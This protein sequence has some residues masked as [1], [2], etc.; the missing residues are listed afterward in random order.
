VN[1]FE[2]V[3]QK[4]RDLITK[5]ALVLVDGMLRFD[6]FSDS[7]R[8]SAKRLT[9]LD[10]VRE[11]QARRLVLKWPQNGDAKALQGR[12]YEILTA[13]RP[14]PCPILIEYTLQR[15]QSPW[16]GAFTLGNDWTV[17][18]TRELLEQLETL[19]GRGGVQVLYGAP[20]P[21]AASMSGS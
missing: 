14:G 16:T 10:K 21:I 12:L 4:Y 6:E 2:D 9:E 7:W 11:Q 19:V 8:L 15:A 17:R 20:P 5:D 3:F 1:L 18:A 13:W